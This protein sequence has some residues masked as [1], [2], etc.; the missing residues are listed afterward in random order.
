MASSTHYSPAIDAFLVSVLYHETRR[1]GVPMTKLVDELLT[2]ALGGLPP[3]VAETRIAT[4][5][6]EPDRRWSGSLRL[7]G[8]NSPTPTSVVKTSRRL[9]GV[10]ALLLVKLAGRHHPKSSANP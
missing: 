9:S 4:D 2:G 10:R 7:W 5:L 8:T 1:R 3:S 6:H